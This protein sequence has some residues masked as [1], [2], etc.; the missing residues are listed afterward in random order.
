MDATDGPAAYTVY[1]NL[2]I[3]DRFHKA[4]FLTNLIVTSISLP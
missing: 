1:S 4:E 3:F 2:S